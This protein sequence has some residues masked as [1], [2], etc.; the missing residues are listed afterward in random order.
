M[1]NELV[2]ISGN[3]KRVMEFLDNVSANVN[4]NIEHRKDDVLSFLFD[5]LVELNDHGSK[6]RAVHL[7][8]YAQ[9]QKVS[10][11]V[12]KR[13]E[14]LRQ[15]VIHFRAVLKFR[16][17]RMDREAWANS[18]YQ[19][20]YENHAGQSARNLAR[21]A[22]DLIKGDEVAIRAGLPP[23]SNPSAEDLSSALND[24]LVHRDKGQNAADVHRKAS[25]DMDAVAHKAQCLYR[26]LAIAL[27]SHHSDLSESA[28]RD[29]MRK[30]GYV[31][32]Q[33][34]NASQEDDAEDPGEASQA[35]V[36]V[37]AGANVP[38]EAAADAAMELEGA[39]VSQPAKEGSAFR[40]QL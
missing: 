32:V 1:S 13:L 19:L 29:I 27:R 7:E 5:R 8:A 12:S 33:D 2:P 37:E 9:R 31:F 28:C 14:L 16:N 15:S 39:G 25:E 22:K 26:M 40:S 3:N 36:D 23:M 24:Y 17:S 38:A 4:D 30:Y 11:K 10:S 35:E 6:V 21:S 18:F 34:S 20:P